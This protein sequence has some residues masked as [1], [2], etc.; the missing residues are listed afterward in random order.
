[1]GAQKILAASKQLPMEFSSHPQRMLIVAFYVRQYKP[2]MKRNTT[3][4]VLTLTA[5][6]HVQAI[7]PQGPS[8]T[9]FAVSLARPSMAKSPENDPAAEPCAAHLG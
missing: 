6:R 7:H 5:P 9:L 1:M 2:P 8:P 4:E 3:A